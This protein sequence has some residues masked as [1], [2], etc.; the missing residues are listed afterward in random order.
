MTVSFRSRAGHA[1]F[2]RDCSQGLF[3]V[4]S[5]RI[6]SPPATHPPIGPGDERGPRISSEP[7]LSH[8]AQWGHSALRRTILPR[9][10]AEHRE[11][12]WAGSAEICSR[13][14]DSAERSICFPCRSA[15]PGRAVRAVAP[16]M[17]MGVGQPIPVH[18][19]PVSPGD[20]ALPPLRVGP[21]RD[22]FSSLTF[23]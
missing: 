10:H 9:V 16:P 22:S 5:I 1:A 18:S 6:L 20:P 2:A 15:L 8:G 21:L 14:G 4:K 12:G 7:G 17:V 3:V 11:E 23:D 13:Y 19:F